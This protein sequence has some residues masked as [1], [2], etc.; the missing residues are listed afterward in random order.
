MPNGHV[1]RMLSESFA[2]GKSG[3]HRLIS[4]SPALHE[5]RI[6]FEIADRGVC[7]MGLSESCVGGRGGVVFVAAAEE[8]VPEAA[9]LLWFGWWRGQLGGQGIGRGGDRGGSGRRRFG[10]RR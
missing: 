2:T 6:P 1:F 10:D 5:P 4:G 3:S 9:F 8:P 7:S